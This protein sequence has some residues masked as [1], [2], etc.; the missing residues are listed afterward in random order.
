MFDDIVN[1]IGGNIGDYEFIVY[2]IACVLLILFVTS[3]CNIFYQVVKS[4]GGF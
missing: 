3:I 2:C 1:W 4:L